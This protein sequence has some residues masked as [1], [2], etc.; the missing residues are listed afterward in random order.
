MTTR[1]P[2]TGS[3]NDRDDLRRRGQ[4]VAGHP[5]A[6]GTLAVVG[7]AV[8]L[9]GHHRAAAERGAPAD[10]RQRL[11]GVPAGRGPAGARPLAER[12]DGDAL[13]RA[14]AA[15]R[16]RAAR[17]RPTTR[18]SSTRPPAAEQ[19]TRVAPPAARERVGLLAG[20]RLAMVI[21][22]SS[23]SWTIAPEPAAAASPRRA[24]RRGEQPAD[25]AASRS[26][27]AGTGRALATAPTALRREPGQRRRTDRAPAWHRP[28]A[29]PRDDV[30][31]PAG[32]A[33][34]SARARPPDVGARAR[35]GAAG[36]ATVVP[37]GR[38]SVRASGTPSTDL[39]TGAKRRG[40]GGVRSTT[41]GVTGGETASGLSTRSS[42][43]DPN[44]GACAALTTQRGDRRPPAARPP[45]AR[46]RPARSARRRSASPAVSTLA[47]SFSA[48]AAVT[49]SSV[50]AVLVTNGSGLRPVERQLDLVVVDRRR[51]GEEAVRAGPCRSVRPS[52]A[53][54]VSPAGTVLAF[55]FCAG[56]QTPF[57]NAAAG[58][59]GQRDAVEV[60]ELAVVGGR[61]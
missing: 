26:A 27:A 2:L 34:R 52:H 61:A 37:A 45:P 48:I 44:D 60:E 35:H 51:A 6:V 28:A 41:T 46:A 47:A 23:P 32:C 59:R 58:A 42:A 24:V 3:V 5:A 25:I 14:A 11:P 18:S 17:R 56:P 29:R 31:A 43:S 10:R 12:D 21:T 20:G 19:R 38:S 55:G 49:R 36:V 22:A 15:R 53:S 7:D 54:M 9:R 40:G 8:A 30:T 1:R 4:L 50:F 39:T 16:R 33:R 13:G 57:G